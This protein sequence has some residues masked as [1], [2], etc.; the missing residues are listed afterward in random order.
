MRYKNQ[1]RNNIFGVDDTN[2]DNRELGKLNMEYAKLGV[3]RRIRRR[4]TQTYDRFKEKPKDFSARYG[5]Q[6]PLGF[7]EHK[8][9]NGAMVFGER[10]LK[11]GEL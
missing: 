6:R 11:T 7:Q 4:N 2:L 5:A 1:R 10:F 8:L 9:F 3:S